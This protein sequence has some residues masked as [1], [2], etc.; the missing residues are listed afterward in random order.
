[1]AASAALPVE[2]GVTSDPNEYAPLRVLRL[3]SVFEAPTASLAGRGTAYDPLGGMQNHTGQLTRALDARGVVQAVVT[4]YRPSAPRRERI[5]ERTVVHRVGLPTRHLRQ[6]WAPPA[7]ALALRLASGC[8][9]VHAHLG[10]DYAVVPLGLAAAAVAGRPLVITVHSS[11]V[12]TFEVTGLRSFALKR[13]GSPLER[14]GER[15]A[16]AVITLT[17]RTARLLEADGVPGDRVHVI[18]SGV[19]PSRF[20]GPAPER[21][22]GA[23][24]RVLYLGRLHVQKGLETLVCA[25]AALPPDVE[26]V[27]AGDGPERPHLESLARRTGVQDRV[28][29]L[30]FVPPEEVPALLPTA[31]V[32]VLPSRYEELGSVLLE[33]MTCGLPIVATRT[34]GVPSVI[35]DGVA[36]ILV[37]PGEPD[38]MAAA[39]RQLLDDD[40]L[41][42]RLR[43]G[44][45]EASRRYH[46]DALAA[47]VH[48]LYRSV[49][50]EARGATEPRAARPS[51]SV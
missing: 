38:P 8:D 14:L 48:D 36:G 34:G 24:R 16:A 19:R 1:V 11:L 6:V 18:P 26:V 3:C 31:D 47:Q 44:A 29:F 7:A 23:R 46:W 49:V 21:T 35:A 25:A 41:A 33:A 42:G 51:G 45:R 10:D 4:A 28:R 43:A 30:G 39:I 15:R 37:P 5:G 12:H 9:L 2:S 40:R 50:D 22:R 17:D 13:L 27:L 32:F 20:S